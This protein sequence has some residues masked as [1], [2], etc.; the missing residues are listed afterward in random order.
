MRLSDHDSRDK[1]I[2]VAFFLLLQNIL[3]AFMNANLAKVK[4]TLQAITLLERFGKL[5]IEKLEVEERFVSFFLQFGKD[6]EDIKVV[7]ALLFQ[8]LVLL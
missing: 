7:C 5:K 2:S 4:T 1:F 6:L 3:Y 8:V